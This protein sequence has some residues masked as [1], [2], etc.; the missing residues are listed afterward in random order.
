MTTLEFLRH[1]RIAGY[2]IFDIVVSFSGIYLLSGFL[3]KIFSKIRISVPK[4]NW[5]YL[6]LPIGIITHLIF[7]QLTP[8]TKNFLDIHSHYILKIII[9]GFIIL[10]LRGIKIIK[11]S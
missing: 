4:I 3:T 7:G 1:F 9:I 11:K 8:M 6:T 5:V 2:A 10:G